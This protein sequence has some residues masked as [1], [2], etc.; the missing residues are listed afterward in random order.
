M[1]NVLN[2]SDA[3]LQKNEDLFAIKEEEEVDGDND[4]RKMSQIVVKSEHDHKQTKDNAK[5]NSG[6]KIETKP[7]FVRMV[8]RGEKETSPKNNGWVKKNEKDNAKDNTNANS[9]VDSEESDYIEAVN[10]NIIIFFSYE[11]YNR[12]RLKEKLLPIVQNL[13]IKMLNG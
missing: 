13:D 2:F 11:N 7:S 5:D 3:P 4:K 8:S 1:K 6:K 9:K 10:I 12:K